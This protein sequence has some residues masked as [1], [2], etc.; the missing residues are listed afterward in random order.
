MPV[1]VADNPLVQHKLGILRS[2]GATAAE[3]RAAASDM[4]MLLLSEAAGKLPVED[5]AVR[6]WFGMASVTA[7]CESRI[8]LVPILRAGLGLMDGA[9]R[10][11]P[12]AGV[13]IVGLC[14]NE[15]SLEPVQYYANLVPEIRGRL[16]IILDPML[17][18]GGSALAC[19]DMLKKA[20]CK[21]ICA[22]HIVCAPEGLER[23][24]AAHPDV[25]IYTAA[26]DDGLN[27]CGYILPGLGDAGDRL[28]GTA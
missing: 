13:S 28:F 14:R 12:G 17:A 1:T 2:R 16:A 20:G 18:T 22:L 23:I 26:I 9:L 19:I 4:A 25:D 27:K 10:M 24:G 15:Q 3:F 7:I 5:R 6:G 21:N 11:L 8:T